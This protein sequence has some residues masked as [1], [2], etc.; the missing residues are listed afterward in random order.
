MSEK[1]PRPSD[2]TEREF[3]TYWTPEM[4]GIAREY[5]FKL[6]LQWLGSLM[7]AYNHLEH[8]IYEAVSYL[9]NEQDF[10]RGDATLGYFRGFKT[11]LDVFEGLFALKVTD[12]Q[13]RQELKLLRKQIQEHAETRNVFAHSRLLMPTEKGAAAALRIKADDMSNRVHRV[14]LNQLIDTVKTI[15]ACEHELSTFCDTHLPS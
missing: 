11:V 12:P 8:R 13:A 6:T 7:V 4:D 3:P 1:S 15:D 9:I 5:D 10:Q 2:S 14:T